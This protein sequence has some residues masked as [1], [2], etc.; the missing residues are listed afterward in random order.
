MLNPFGVR[1]VRF[2]DPNGVIHLSPGSYPGN[3]S[4]PTKKNPAPQRG[5]TS[6]PWVS[7]GEQINPPQKNPGRQWNVEP[8]WGSPGAIYGPQRGHTSEPRVLPGEQI[9]PHQKEP[10]TPTGCNIPDPG[11]TRGTNHPTKNNTRHPNGMLNPFRVL[12]FFWL[13][14]IPRVSR[15]Y[16]RTFGTLD[17]HVEPFWGSFCLCDSQKCL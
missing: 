7:P 2:T 11:P 6:Q 15:Q 17:L 8:L 10:S 1:L 16:C 9:K 4:S 5:A 3:K 12:L 14:G 13:C